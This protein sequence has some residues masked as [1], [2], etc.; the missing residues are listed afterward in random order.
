LYKNINITKIDNKGDMDSALFGSISNPG[1]IEKEM[2]FKKNY[3][4]LCADII[5]GMQIF[6]FL[7]LSL[8]DIL[9][10]FLLGLIIFVAR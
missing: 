10:I 9:D 5:M 1:E 7:Y 2:M 4:Y 6:D 8:A 3:Y